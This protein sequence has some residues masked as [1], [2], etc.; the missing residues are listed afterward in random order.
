MHASRKAVTILIVCL[1]V[2]VGGC[3]K[4]QLISKYDDQTDAAATK[5][6]R[7]FSDFFVKIASAA[8]PSERSYR[9]NIA[10][11]RTAAV[12]F[13]ALQVR[14]S[15]IYKNRI[16]RNQI[17]LTQTNFAYLLLLHKGCVSGPLTQEQRETVERMG[18][19]LSMDCQTAYGATSDVPDRGDV[20][21]RPILAAV[22]QRLLD[23]Q[24]GAILALELAKKRG[25]DK[26][27]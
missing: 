21:L 25:E 10:F 23:Q 16:T 17:D 2:I 26:E 27:E 5:L 7:E 8:N 1:G 19:D 13:A 11:Y 15:A 24:F 3:T 12:D 14:A 4:I 18:P 6:Q 20:Q 22:P 9:N